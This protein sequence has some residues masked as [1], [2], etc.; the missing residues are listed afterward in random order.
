LREGYLGLIFGMDRNGLDLT[1]GIDLE[2][3]Y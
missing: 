2:I 3:I 1:K